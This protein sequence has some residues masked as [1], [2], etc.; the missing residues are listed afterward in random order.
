MVANP[1]VSTRGNIALQRA[2][3]L[4]SKDDVISRD[5][6]RDLYGKSVDR[7]SPWKIRMFSGVF[8]QSWESEN[9]KFKVIQDNLQ[10]DNFKA[11]RNDG[12][13]ALNN[14]GTNIILEGDP[15]G[16]TLDYPEDDVSVPVLLPSSESNDGKGEFSSDLESSEDP[17]SPDVSSPSCSEEEEDPADQVD[18]S[19]VDDPPPPPPAPPDPPPPEEKVTL[20]MVY[21]KMLAVRAQIECLMTHFNLSTKGKR[22]KFILVEY[23][24]EDEPLGNLKDK[25]SRGSSSFP[26]DMASRSAVSLK[27]SS[28]TNG[29]MGACVDHMFEDFTSDD[30]AEVHTDVEFPKKEMHENEKKSLSE[31]QEVFEAASS[32]IRTSEDTRRK[33]MISDKKARVSKSATPVTKVDNEKAYTPYAWINDDR[34]GGQYQ[35]IRTILENPGKFVCYRMNADKQPCPW[36]GL[37]MVGCAGPLTSWNEKPPSAAELTKKGTST[38]VIPFVL[39]DTEAFSF[40][41][42]FLM[43]SGLPKIRGGMGRGR[44]PES[45]N[46]TSIVKERLQQWWGEYISGRPLRMFLGPSEVLTATYLQGLELPSLETSLLAKKGVGNMFLPNSLESTCNDEIFCNLFHSYKLG[47]YLNKHSNLKGVIIDAGRKVP[48]SLSSHFST[49]HHGTTG[50][51]HSSGEVVDSSTALVTYAVKA[52]GT[53]G[54]IVHSSPFSSPSELD[55]KDPGQLNS[56]ISTR[57]KEPVAAP[58]ATLVKIPKYDKD[59]LMNYITTEKDEK[60]SVRF[61]FQSSFSMDLSG[62]L[63]PSKQI[64]INIPLEKLLHSKYTLD[65]IEGPAIFFCPCCADSPGRYKG[66]RSNSLG[67]LWHDTLTYLQDAD[68]FL[69]QLR[70]SKEYRDKFENLGLSIFLKESGNMPRR[71]VVPD[72]G[73][74]QE[75]SEVLESGLRLGRRAITELSLPMTVCKLHCAL[76]VTTVGRQMLL[77]SLHCY[78]YKEVK[79]KLR[80]DYTTWN[81]QF[82]SVTFRAAAEFYF[83]DAVQQIAQIDAVELLHRMLGDLGVLENLEIA[84]FRGL[85]T[86]R[87]EKSDF[88]QYVRRF[89]LILRGPQFVF[90]LMLS[91]SFQQSTNCTPTKEKVSIFDAWLLAPDVKMVESLRWKNESRRFYSPPQW[92]KDLESVKNLNATVSSLKYIEQQ[93]QLITGQIARHPNKLKEPAKEDAAR[94]DVATL[95]F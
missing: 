42:S 83:P 25:R 64:F 24:S 45:C 28:A 58:T 48:Q 95:I 27:G 34:L 9:G 49:V 46:C 11:T 5:P 7:T 76:G 16:I 30:L 26:I 47:C 2:R 6:G 57:D 21:N 1:Q 32:Y 33:K 20:P 77:D 14:N 75:Y 12:G 70:N 10:N 94:E 54:Q 67:I 69:S 18:V 93:E 38:S 15:Q 92:G 31:E 61:G 13:H 80:S 37:H 41:E 23:D 74:P 60:C 36:D 56:E 39:D 53:I 29:A 89:K 73:L 81:K 68:L 17:D 86:H 19:P 62:P 91:N 43:I 85:L 71:R 52:L 44:H 65:C 90:D 66:L 51:E 3:R 4:S 8:F 82:K 87:L 84:I 55:E 88:E 59:H 35:I 79:K 78:D 40:I 50:E 63:P 72:Q 22:K